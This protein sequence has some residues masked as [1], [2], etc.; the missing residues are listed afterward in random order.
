MEEK[1]ELIKSQEKSLSEEVEVVSG[2][3]KIVAV[4]SGII[5]VVLAV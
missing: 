5:L 3:G 4:V 2:K 1:D